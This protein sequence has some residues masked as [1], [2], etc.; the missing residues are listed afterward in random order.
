M[1]DAMVKLLSGEITPTKTTL[2]VFVP[3]GREVGGPA[4]VPGVGALTPEATAALDDLLASAKV[5]E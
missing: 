4:Y 5:T 1:A 2:H 3:K